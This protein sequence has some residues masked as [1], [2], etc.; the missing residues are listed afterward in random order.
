MQ[1]F[2]DNLAREYARAIIAI[3]R[4]AHRK[5]LALVL[6]AFG[7]F[8]AADDDGATL[9]RKIG[10]LKVE[11]MRVIS[12]KRAGLLAQ[13]VGGRVRRFTENAVGAQV[14]AAIGI[15]PLAASSATTPAILSGFVRENV[16]LIRTVPER[17]FD[18]INDV[19]QES[20][21]IGRHARDVSGLLQERFAVS[22][23]NAIRIARDQI[24]KLNGQITR[25]RQSDL[26][27][28]HYIWRTSRDERVRG[29]PSG[30]YPDADPSHFDLE[31]TRHAWNDPPLAGVDGEPAHPGEAIQCRCRAEP[32][33]RA[34]VGNVFDDE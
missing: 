8:D 29:D 1:P 23:T 9:G 13:G 3:M 21:R 2:P 10:S 11:T 12:T 5:A 26:G 14:K 27:I 32:D 7:R 6:P 34:L 22:E 33:V 16:D 15:N 19:V 24:G 31:G 17:Y 28:T 25:A 4:D 30:K 18:Q 20:F